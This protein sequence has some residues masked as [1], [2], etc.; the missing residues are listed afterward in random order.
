VNYIEALEQYSRHL[1]PGFSR[2]AGTLERLQRV[3][4]GWDGPKSPAISVEAMNV[5]ARLA[6]DVFPADMVDL[7]HVAPIPNGM[8]Q[9]EW[10][11]NREGLE[12]E[13]EA[14]DK[15]R[16]LRWAPSRG[17]EDEDD[18]PVSDTGRILELL[19]WF[20]ENILQ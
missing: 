2:L 5:V 19:K 10:Y 13:L 14:P 1:H 16:Y 12:L 20:K 7:M 11:S 3:K 6:L 18:V 9:M 8:L 17:I 4:P 15:I